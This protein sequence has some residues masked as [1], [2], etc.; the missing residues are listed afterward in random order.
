MKFTVVQRFVPIFSYVM[1]CAMCLTTNI[2]CI[3][4]MCRF[5]CGSGT[6][7]VRS[8]ET[9]VLNQWNSITVYRHRWDAWILLN[10][11]NRVQGRSK[12]TSLKPNNLTVHVIHT[13]V[14]YSII[15]HKKIL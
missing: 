3:L 9:V 11:G 8:D 6:G 10:E 14:Q 15:F 5:D 2:I 1:K 7:K 4:F 13:T 12:V